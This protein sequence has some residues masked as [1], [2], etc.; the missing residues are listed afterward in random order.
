[1]TKEE[2]TKLRTALLCIA[3][4]MEMANELQEMNNCNNCGAR[5]YCQYAPEL[6]KP[7]RWNCPF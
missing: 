5:K 2:R 4:C 3:D 1:M 6:G 7:V